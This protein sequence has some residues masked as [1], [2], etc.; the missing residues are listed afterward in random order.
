MARILFVHG[1]GTKPSREDERAR[2]WAPIAGSLWLPVPY[3]A[4]D[5]LYW[6]DLRL[7][8]D[9]AAPLQASDAR[10]RHMP[11]RQRMDFEWALG[12][13]GAYASRPDLFALN[14]VERWGRMM[15]MMMTGVARR[16]EAQLRSSMSFMLRDL[17]PYLEGRTRDPIRER[18]MSQ[19]DAAR[20]KTPLCVVSHSMGT[21]VAL[22]SVMAWGGPVDTFVTLGA[23]LGWEYVKEALGRP[24]FP[25]N[26]RRWFNLY[27][28]FDNCVWPDRS[29]GND[30]LTP[31]GGRAVIDMEVRDNYAPN[32]D[33]DPHHWH[34]YLGS[35]EFADI[36]CKF[37]LGANMSSLPANSNGSAARRL[38]TDVVL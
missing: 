31:E 26:I 29:I 32:G 13:L 24:V 38:P 17:V 28:R 37:W 22:D 33:R 35:P 5:V 6:S 23:P 7:A 19:L 16:A 20:D 11:E 30:Y 12:G 2:M 9:D 21:V 18:I 36:V 27:D 8:D 10:L 25:P 15:Q 34:G 1:M 3:D 4:F 14:A